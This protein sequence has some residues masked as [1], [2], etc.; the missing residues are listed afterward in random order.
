MFA[1]TIFRRILFN[2]AFIF[3]FLS[4]YILLFYPIYI[5]EHVMIDFA[6]NPF[7]IC[8]TYPELWDKLKLYFIV[9]S[10][11]SSLIIINLF[12]SSIFSKKIKKSHTR[13]NKDKGLM[14]L[15]SNDGSG[16]PIILPEASLYQNILITGTIGS[17]KTSS[18]MYP[19]T[20]QLIK[21]KYQDESSK[22]GM[23]I[24]DVK[25]NYYSQ[26]KKY[27]S[28]YRRTKDVIIIELRRKYKVQSIGQA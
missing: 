13:V 23:L 20:R 9:I 15:V 3:V 18:A 2:F 28:Y 25:G 16:N 5:A 27:A 1:D 11:S 6:V 22:L 14:L 4:I 12:Y 24:L 8:E 26:V 17:G 19:F 21:Y 10:G 7:D